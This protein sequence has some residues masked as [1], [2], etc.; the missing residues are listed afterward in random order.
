[1]EGLVI[2]TARPEDLEEVLRLWQQMVEFHAA[3]DPSLAMR[4]DAEAVESMRTYLQASLESPDG[5]LLV[6][7]V[8]GI[9]GL[10]GY[11]LGHVRSVAPMAIPPTCGVISDICVEESLRQRGIGR[12]LFCA[13]RDWFRE[14]GQTLVR[15]HA[16]TANPVSQAF[17]RAMGGVEQMVLMRIE[18]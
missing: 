9:G 12:E 13:A 5:L 10:V 18:I 16:A 11:L 14:R 3:C 8:A 2:R 6:A 17:W 15:L 1:M 7:E 4:T